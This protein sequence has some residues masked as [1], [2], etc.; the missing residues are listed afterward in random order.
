MFIKICDKLI[1]FFEWFERLLNINNRLYCGQEYVEVLK[2][3]ITSKCKC[4]AE[5]IQFALTDRTPNELP[6]TIEKCCFCAKE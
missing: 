6:N 5:F 1:V 2:K 3:P 4:G